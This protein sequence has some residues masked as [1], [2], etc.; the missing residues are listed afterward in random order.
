MILDEFLRNLKK[1]GD[2]PCYY[3]DGQQTSYQ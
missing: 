3:S 1:E 2:K